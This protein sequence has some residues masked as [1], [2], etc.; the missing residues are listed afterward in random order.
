MYTPLVPEN[1]ICESKICW[2]CK[3]NISK[4]SETV[5]LCIT[6]CGFLGNPATK[7][8]CQSC[9]KIST[10]I[11]TSPAAALTFIRLSERS[12]YHQRRELIAQAKKD[13]I[14]GDQAKNDMT[15]MGLCRWVWR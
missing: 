14:E 10:G 1:S 5:T 11:K 13:G 4:V 3:I 12:D 8:M 9:Y 15:T 6:N 2:P 7:N